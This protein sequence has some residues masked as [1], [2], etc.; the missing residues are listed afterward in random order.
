MVIRWARLGSPLSGMGHTNLPTADSVFVPVQVR[1]HALHRVLGTPSVSLGHLRL[2]VVPQQRV[3]LRRRQHEEVRHRS[4]LEPQPQRRGQDQLGHPLRPVGRQLR[5]QHPAVGM[6]QQGG[7]FQTQ[8]LEE[9][10]IEE[11]QVPE[12]VQVFQPLAGS[13]AGMGRRDD[14]VLLRQPFQEGRPTGEPASPVEI[15]QVG[16]GTSLHYLHVELPCL[17]RDHP[18]PV[19][20]SRSFHHKNTCLR[21]PLPR[22]RERWSRPPRERSRLPTHH[23]TPPP[24]RTLSLG[25]L[26]TPL[27]GDSPPPQRSLAKSRQGRG[28]SWQPPVIPPLDTFQF[29]QI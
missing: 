5:G 2:G 14:V 7:P 28:I 16:S 21:E 12:I 8:F 27:P 10:L 25:P 20:G 26:Q 22:R 15:D 6:A 29:A 18:L 11:H 23:T 24:P 9:F 13:H 3:P 4:V 19:S 17:H 1:L